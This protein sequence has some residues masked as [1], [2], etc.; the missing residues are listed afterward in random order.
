MTLLVTSC[1]W[2]YSKF[3]DTRDTFQVTNIFFSSFSRTQMS[4]L[5]KINIM[6]FVTNYNNRDR[7]CNVA[8]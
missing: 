1:L 6:Q 7:E 8:Q 5:L 2:G 4:Q 3:H